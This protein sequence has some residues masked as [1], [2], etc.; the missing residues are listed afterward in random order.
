MGSGVH[1]SRYARSAMSLEL[2]EITLAPISQAY[3]GPDDRCSTGRRNYG[4][5][6]GG[7]PRAQARSSSHAAGPSARC[8]GDARRGNAVAEPM[9]VHRPMSPER[10]TRVASRI[11]PPLRGISQGGGH[12]P[13]RSL[14]RRLSAGSLMLFHGHLSVEVGPI[15]ERSSLGLVGARRHE[16]PR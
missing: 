5:G 16:H 13:V 11:G 4:D 1:V 2:I 8:D 9:E 14:P 15:P 3:A 7:S 10:Q 12:I 6:S